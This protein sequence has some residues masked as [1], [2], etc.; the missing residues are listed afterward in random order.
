[1]FHI[2]RRTH[3]RVFVHIPFIGHLMATYLISDTHYSH[4]GILSFKNSTTG[5]PVRPQFKNIDEMDEFMLDRWNSVVRKGDTVIHLGDV[6][7][8][9]QDRFKKLWPKLN[10]SKKLIVGNHDNIKFLAAGGFFSEILMWK[11]L[12]RH[13]I[14]LSHVPVHESSLSFYGRGPHPYRSWFKCHGHIHTEPT[15]EGPYRNFSVEVIGYTPVD[16]EQV[17]ADVETYWK[18]LGL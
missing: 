3:G 10:G 17:A 14:L 4:E 12:P 11:R 9:D 16:V 1:M 6:F 8:G 15:P 2:D 7:F 18:G 5:L 13:S